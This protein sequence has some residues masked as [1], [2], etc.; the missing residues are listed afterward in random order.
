MAAMLGWCLT[1]FHSTLF[2]TLFASSK[3]TR[4]GTFQLIPYSTGGYLIPD[5]IEPEF[6]R[7][8]SDLR[9]DIIIFL[10]NLN[11]RLLPHLFS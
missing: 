6:E 9:F 8:L 2:V 4:T 7:P 11:V 5:L 1:L 10:R 3:T